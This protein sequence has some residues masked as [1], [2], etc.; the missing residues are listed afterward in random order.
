MLLVEHGMNLGLHSDGKSVLLAFKLSD[1][2]ATT[3]ALP[4]A[5]MWKRINEPFSS[6]T[7]GTYTYS[8]TQ[9]VARVLPESNVQ[10]ALL[11]L[12]RAYRAKEVFYADDRP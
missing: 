5:D 9:H 12:L 1:P 11:T 7:D 4:K 6:Y 2:L 10:P 3:H 8:P